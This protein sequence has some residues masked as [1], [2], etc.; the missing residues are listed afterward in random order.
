MIC[1]VQWRRKGNFKGHKLKFGV[2]KLDNK[3]SGSGFGK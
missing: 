1:L 3:Q 2:E